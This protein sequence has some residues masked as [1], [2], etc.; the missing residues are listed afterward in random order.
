MR[1]SDGIELRESGQ[2][3]RRK[4][5][6]RLLT[7]HGRYGDDFNM[8]GQAYAVM[9][10]SPYPHAKILSI[11]IRAARAMAGVL[12]VFS[13]ADCR[14]DGLAA[15]PHGPV[16]STKFDMKLTGPGGGK[17]FVDSHVLLPVKRA[18]YVGE[19]VAM[20]VAATTEQ[21]LDAAEAIKVEYEELPWVAESE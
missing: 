5:D 13:G 18:R 6:L 19:A 9:L 1:T 14:A 16:P 15:I 2:P 4:E 7:G 3:L 8:P 12:G 11:D 21:A 17:V 10:R 20:V